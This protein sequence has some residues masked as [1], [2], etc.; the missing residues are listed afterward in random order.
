MKKTLTKERYDMF[1]KDTLVQKHIV[2]ESN[3][4]YRI[5]LEILN[6]YIKDNDDILDVGCGAGVISFYFASKGHK[7]YGI[8]ISERAIDSCI[9]SLKILKLKTASFSVMDFPSRIPN[10]TFDVVI[11]CEVLEHLEDD[12]KA[13]KQIFALLKKGGIAIISTPSKNAP[14]FRIGYVNNF[15]KKVGHLR[16]YNLNE[17]IRKSNKYGFIILETGK[18]EGIIRNFLFVNPIAGKL[19]RYIKFFVSDL[20]TFVDNLVIALLGES[21]MFI[22]VK[23]P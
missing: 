13:F 16:R 12:D 7:V 6:K 1:H 11:M 21:N 8:D 5:I 19:V 14:L 17:L 23:K 20:I 15:D 9:N 3:F 2:N 22:I 4:T 10:K 18:T